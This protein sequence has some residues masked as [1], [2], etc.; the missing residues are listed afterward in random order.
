MKT[1]REYCWN[2]ITSTECLV[3]KKLYRRTFLDIKHEFNLYVM[4][5]DLQSVNFHI[6]VMTNILKLYFP[7]LINGD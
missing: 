7:N 2:L 3:L 5:T 6:F 4:K 1:E